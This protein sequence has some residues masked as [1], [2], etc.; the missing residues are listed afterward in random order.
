ML[1]RKNLP[2]W[3][4]ALRSVAG[5][6]MFAGGLFAPGLAGSPAGYIIAAAGVM[7]LL[8]GFVGYCPACAFAGRR[9]K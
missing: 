6:S 4:R 1:F 5:V 9:L 2:I 8:T 3:E 7:T